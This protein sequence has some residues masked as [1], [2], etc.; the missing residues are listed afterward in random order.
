MV[1]TFSLFLSE[2]NKSTNKLNVIDGNPPT[3]SGP[4]K[5]TLSSAGLWQL[6]QPWKSTVFRLKLSMRHQDSEV[7]SDSAQI[8][9]PLAKIP[10]TKELN[11]MHSK[12]FRMQSRS[13]PFNPPWE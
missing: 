12:F 7:L 6:W 3:R 1:A 10:G 2:R 11:P 8:S 13:A 4:Q 9:L 5:V